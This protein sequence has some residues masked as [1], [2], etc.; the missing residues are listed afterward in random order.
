MIGC[1]RRRRGT[2]FAPLP[3][4]EDDVPCAAVSARQTFRVCSERLGRLSPG[5]QDSTVSR[6][7]PR[8]TTMNRRELIQLGLSSVAATA[9]P[10]ALWAQGSYPTRPIRLIVPFSPGGVVDVTG[11][12]WADQ[13][14]TSL[15]TVVVENLSGAGGTRGASDVA[16]AEPDGYTVLLGNTSTQVLNPAIMPKAPY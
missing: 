12:L 16:R 11:R 3:F 1:A 15:G 9:L 13:V 10:S 8:G 4:R 6:H 5:V 14:K 7:Q 2:T